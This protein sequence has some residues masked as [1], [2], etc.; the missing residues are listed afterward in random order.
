MG[1]DR[2]QRELDYYKKFIPINF[3]EERKHFFDHLKKR[4]TYNPM[5][6]YADLL[7]VEDYE[8]I[9]SGLIKE[10]GGDE[11]I[12]AFLDVYTHV[13]DIM[14]SWRIGDYHR[15]CDQSGEIFGSVNDFDIS[16]IMKEYRKLEASPFN[17]AEIY[18]HE[19]IKEKFQEEF[20]KRSLAGWVV[21]YNEA[22]PGNVS[23]YETEKKVVIRTGAEETELGLA[24][25]LS[26][27]LDGHAFQAFNA[28]EH[29][30]YQ[31]WFL[32]Y[33][34][35]E[36]QYEGYATFVEINNLS[37]L[38]IDDEMAQYFVFMVATALA[39]NFSFYET[40]QEVYSLCGDPQFSFFATY[41]AK[42]GLGDTAQAGC[43]QKENCYLSGALEIVNLVEEDQK[44][45]Y[46]L[47]QGCFP[48][49]ILRFIPDEKPKWISVN[50]LNTE[51]L[52]YFK[53]KM[54]K[55]KKQ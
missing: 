9:K 35:T 7:T 54:G 51:N 53:N 28:M 44:N 5:F 39:K 30:K 42:R 8:D 46:R 38:H 10:K 37:T 16:H 25:L 40:Y 17:S 50:H 6:K 33:L 36:R 45:I 24:C 1:F 34:G 31:K 20:R 12:D 23:I 52:R 14:I 47:S 18:N 43:F 2:I 41:K 15:L 29:P 3:A 49:S 55:I 48:F 22:N 26:H 11:V 32:S 13:A 4:K 27:E 21:E 19:H